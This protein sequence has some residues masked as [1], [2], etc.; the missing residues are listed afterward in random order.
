M[1]HYNNLAEVLLDK[2][3][4]PPAGGLFFEKSFFNDTKLKDLKNSRYWVMSSKEAMEL[5]YIED[6]RGARIPVTLKDFNVKK[7]LDIQIF[8]GIIDL[9]LENSP[10]LSLDQVDVFVEAILYYLE[11]DD[12]MD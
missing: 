8:E 1:T 9:K 5:D 12:F 3:N 10:E 4:F 2:D 7:I 11:N 6:E